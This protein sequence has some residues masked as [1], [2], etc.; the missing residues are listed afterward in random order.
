MKE[1]TNKVATRRHERD[2]GDQNETTAVGDGETVGNGETT[3]NSETTRDDERLTGGNDES[4]QTMEQ[5]QRG[6]GM[7]AWGVHVNVVE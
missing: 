5:R 1:T 6:D 2:A 4:G 7:L 3:G